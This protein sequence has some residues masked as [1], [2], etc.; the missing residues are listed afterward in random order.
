MGP[1]MGSFHVAPAGPAESRGICK[2]WK[3]ALN[4]GVRPVMAPGLLRE[5]LPMS[6]GP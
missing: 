2:Y 4:M 5:R 3:K 6:L 1:G